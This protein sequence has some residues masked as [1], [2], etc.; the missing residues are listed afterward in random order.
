[1][2][3]IT[4]PV[5]VPWAALRPQFG[6]A[7]KVVRNFPSAMR[8]DTQMALSVYEQAKVEVQDRGLLLFPS[9]RL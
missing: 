5:F 8:D 2:P 3:H 7:I 4:E 1:L 9:P 6:K